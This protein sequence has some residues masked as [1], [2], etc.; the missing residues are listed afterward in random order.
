MKTKGDGGTHQVKSEVS[1]TASPILVRL[2][3]RG[4]WL[5]G[6]KKK[7]KMKKKTRGGRRKAGRG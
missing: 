2:E 3:E 5:I 1:T 4:F 7:K 6:R